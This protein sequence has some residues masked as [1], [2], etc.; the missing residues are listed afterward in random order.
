MTRIKALT[1]AVL[2]AASFAQPRAAAPTDVFFSE[3]IEGSAN[4]KA[5]EIFNGTGAPVD[6]A[7]GG[8]NVQMY[9]NGSSSAGLTI[10][11]TGAVASGDVYVLA[12]SAAGPAILA[13]ADQ[14]NG[15]GWFNGDDAVVLRKGGAAGTV[16]DAI[17]QIGV[18]PGTEWGSGL[19]STADNTLRRKTALCG[20]DV[21]SGD[22]FVP[23]L[24]WDG[25]ANDTFDGL[26]APTTECDVVVPDDAPSVIS[27]FPVD[28]ASTVSIGATLSVTFSEAVTFGAASYSLTC[29]ASGVKAATFSGGPVTFSVD[30]VTDFVAGESCVFTIIAANV[31]DADGNDP[32]DFMAVNFVVDFTTFD[33]C[34]ATSI[35]AW[36]IQGTGDISPLAGQTVLTRGVVVG[37]FEGPSPTLRGFYIQDAAGDGNNLTSDGLFVF[38]GNANA[39]SLGQVA[40]VTGTVSEFQGQTQ[41]SA[42]SVTAC[43]SGTTRP[44]EVFL[45]V[46]NEAYFERVEGML[47]RLPQ[48]LAVTEH[49]QLGRF[50]QVVV[51][52]PRSQ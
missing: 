44:V 41:V 32:P 14:T 40:A 37:D 26:G 11:L 18:D 34:T 36:Q 4:N 31:S 10:S 15:A 21:N 12:Q 3:Y 33:P 49:F 42:T 5:L 52:R 22:L 20:G 8:Y 38:N 6:L 19:A 2:L 30:P 27:T 43:G 17:G 24:E 29:S 23:S 13:Q 45:P 7:A 28:G 16:L 35:P 39:V 46:P 1:A 25:F 47:V 50:G 51:A 48:E 9:F